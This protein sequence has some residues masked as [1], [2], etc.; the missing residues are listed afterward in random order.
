MRF[1]VIWLIVGVALLVAFVVVVNVVSDSSDRL[2]AHGV[3]EAGTITQLS[4]DRGI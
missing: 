1:I 2:R 3:R 4:P